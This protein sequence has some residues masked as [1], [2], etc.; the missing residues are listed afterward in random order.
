MAYGPSDRSEVIEL[1]G[2]EEHERKRGTYT[3]IHKKEYCGTSL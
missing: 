3:H 1:V 2:F